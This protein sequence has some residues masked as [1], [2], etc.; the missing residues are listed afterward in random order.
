MLV[1]G[2][3]E[4]EEVTDGVGDKKTVVFGDFPLVEQVFGFLLFPEISRTCEV[5]TQLGGLISS[6]CD[7]K[8]GCV[9]PISGGFGA[10]EGSGGENGCGD[11]VV[12][13][14]GLL[15]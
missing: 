13:C 4:S 2:I 5:A 1:E 12:A 10:G 3:F 8:R 9:E 7:D 6:C 14:A 11:I 15:Y